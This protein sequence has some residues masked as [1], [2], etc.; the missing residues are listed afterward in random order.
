[1]RTTRGRKRDSRK[2]RKG[3]KKARI[4]YCFLRTSC[5]R[6][7]IPRTLLNH[8]TINVGSRGGDNNIQ[9]AA[10]NRQTERKMP[11]APV[12]E[13]KKNGKRKGEGERKGRIERGLKRFTGRRSLALK[14]FP[15]ESSLRCKFLIVFPLQKSGMH[16][17]TDT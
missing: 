8:G 3:L 13:E 1:M 7:T 16:M 6:L 9:W 15:L 11:N 10:A 12:K 4:E 2:G 17:Y 5:L 14:L